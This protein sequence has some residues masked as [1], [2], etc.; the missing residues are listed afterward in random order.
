MQSPAKQGTRAGK[1]FASVSRMGKCIKGERR[2]MLSTPQ[3]GRMSIRDLLE[4][5]VLRAEMVSIWSA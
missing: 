5:A 1:K 3:I 2:W 4:T